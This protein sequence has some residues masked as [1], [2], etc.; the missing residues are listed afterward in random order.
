MMKE[1]SAKEEGEKQIFVTTHSPEVIKH[2][3]MENM[4][5]VSRDEDG[6]ST[7][8]KPAEKEEVAI[9]LENEMG[10]DNLFVQGLLDL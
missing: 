2:A 9:F 5:L 10:L 4:Y 1:Q 7:V 8:T 6:F 3:G